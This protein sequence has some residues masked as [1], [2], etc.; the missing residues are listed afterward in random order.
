MNQRKEAKGF[1]ITG[2]DT[3]VG[4]TIITVALLRLLKTYGLNACGMKPVETGCVRKHEK[5]IP[6]DGRF[7]KTA[8]NLEEP[9][10]TIS[11]C[12]F[13]HPL[14]PLAASCIAGTPVDLEKIKSTYA[15]L[16]SRYDAVIV[17]GV[18]GLLVPVAEDYSVIDLAKDF[19]LPVIVVSGTRLGTLN[20][21]M[22]TVTCARKAGLMVSGIIMNES[23]PPE[24]TPAEKTNEDILMKISP[25]PLFGL[26]PYLKKLD[27]E[28]IEQAAEKYLDTKAL[29]RAL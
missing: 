14:A 22:L 15:R 4:K 11:P 18:G 20:H 23:H 24:N 3:G 16:S 19:G 12:R 9:L 10:D 6:S 17:E 2:T 21:T 28:A 8:A 5:L 1:F 29:R 25:V 13:E 7:I 27:G 26:F